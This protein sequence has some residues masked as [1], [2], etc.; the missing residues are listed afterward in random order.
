M[1]ELANAWIHI[2]ASQ[3]RVFELFT[4]EAGICSWMA[5]EASIDLRPGGA[6]RW[7]HDN[8]VASSGEYVEVLPYD[9]V[10]FTYGW[11]SGPYADVAPG[12]TTVE[13][14]FVPTGSGTEVT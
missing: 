5:K 6:W 3:Q 9:S 2:E 11:E 14:T 10:T 13:V 4:T 7:V 8:D 12:S 1:I